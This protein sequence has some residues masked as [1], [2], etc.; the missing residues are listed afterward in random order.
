[1]QPTVTF[2]KVFCSRT[3][4]K[5]GEAIIQDM[6]SFQTF[7]HLILEGADMQRDEFD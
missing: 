3:I 1:M 2:W 5:D 4:V 6:S 7:G